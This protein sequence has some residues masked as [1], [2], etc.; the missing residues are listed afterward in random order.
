[1][2]IDMHLHTAEYSPD[3]DLSVLEAIARA[4][5]LGID[6]LCVTDH[7]G[8][9]AMR[10]DAASLTQKH[11][12]LIL[13]GA[14]ITAREGD[15][16][17]YNCPDFPKKLFKP[18]CAE[19]VRIAAELGGVVISAHPFRWCGLGIGA[20]VQTLPGIAGIETFNGRA[21]Q[22]ENDR[23]L[24]VAKARNVASIGGSD[25]HRPSAMGTCATRFDIPIRNEADLAT[26][27]LQ[28]ACE[29]VALP[30]VL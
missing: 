4:K 8:K 29:A 1:M 2:L 10:R 26:A 27:I 28:C 18:A 11:G 22:E 21:S 16:L 15:L 17:V 7:G 20:L 12:V 23:A 24:A 3:S 19:V 14:E 5:Q 9:Q 25:A 6:G 30:G 13:V